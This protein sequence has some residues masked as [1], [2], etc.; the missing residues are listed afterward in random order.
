MDSQAQVF[1]QALHVL[2]VDAAQAGHNATSFADSQFQAGR[3][4]GLLEAIDVVK[5][6]LSTEELLRIE[7]Q[8]RKAE[9]ER[10]LMALHG[11]LTTE[12]ADLIDAMLL[13]RSLLRGPDADVVLSA[14][15]SVYFFTSACRSEWYT[16]P[17][18]PA[19]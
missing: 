6:S 14:R 17:A 13:E 4:A 3:K 18:P 15:R 9:R 7:Q 10:T 16:C 2:V 1:E 12:E 8:H 19:D 11:A 5:G